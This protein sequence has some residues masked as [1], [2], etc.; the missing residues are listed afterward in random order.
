MD[1]RLILVSSIVLLYLEKKAG[2]TSGSIELCEEVINTFTLP[3]SSVEVHTGREVIVSLREIVYW[4][5]KNFK[6]QDINKSALIQRIRVATKDDTYLYNAITDPLENEISPED[7]KSEIIQYRKTLKEHLNNVEVKDIIK[8]SFKKINF[9]TGVNDYRDFV[10]DVYEKLE[11]YTHEIIDNK[12]PSVVDSVDFCDNKNVKEVMSR[13]VDELSTAGTLTTGWQ[14]LNRML[15]ENKGIRRGEFI[16]VSAL[17]HNF[18]TG[19]TL[20]LAKHLALYNVPYMRDKTK[21]PL[22]IHF[23]LENELTQNILWLYAN[24]KENETGKSCDLKNIDIEYA[25]KYISEKLS[26]NGYKFHMFRLDPTITSVFE[27]KDIILDFE[28]KGYEI[29]AVVCDYLNMVSRRGVDRSGP[30]GT[31]IRSLFRIMRN[32]C[33]P[34]GIAFITPHQLSTEAKMLVRQGIENFVKEIANKGYYDGCKQLDQ[35]VDVEIF[36]HIEKVDGRSYL[37]VQRGKHRKI[38]ITPEC[39]LH[40]VLPFFEAGSVR[41]DVL[42][43]DISM[44]SPGGKYISD[45]GAEWFDS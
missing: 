21:I 45:G 17:Q 29:H 35:E 15:G 13:S 14:A 28:S 10:R 27:L 9:N 33:A 41:D 4:L 5:I 11:P 24:L 30:T 36:I 37:T 42:G 32:F 8:D 7:I 6:N 40:T 16:L 31:D 38:T 44:K 26:V 20:S 2:E 3:E 18:K 1:P 34:R 43:K 39:H 22:I 23:S 25:S 19:F 12:H